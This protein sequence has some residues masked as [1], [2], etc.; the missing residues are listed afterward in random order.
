MSLTT[1]GDMARHYVLQRRNAVLKQDIDDLVK[2]L[3][4]GEIRD[5]ADPVTGEYMIL[6]DI[7]RSL[8][9]LDGYDLASREARIFADTAQAA[10]G[11]VQDSVEALSGDLILAAQSGTATGLSVASDQARQVFLDLVDRL[12]TTVGGRSVFAGIGTSGPALADGAVMLADLRLA[13]SGLS[14]PT[15]IT[16]TVAAWFDDPG[17][18]FETSGYV[19]EEV[20]LA[21]F[22]VSEASE[23]Q[24]T[25]TAY[26]PALRAVLK[27]A[28]LA[29][30]AADDALELCAE[31]QR[32]L[33]QQAGQQIVGDVKG[34]TEL[35][36]GVGAT[37]EAIA[38]GEAENAAA[39]SGFTLLKS[40]MVAA[41]PYETATQLEEPRV[42]LETRYAVTARLAGM[43]LARYLG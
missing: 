6:G 33:L 2:V 42:Q 9:L 21:P 25:I 40:E 34:L 8:R 18:G 35:R 13:V 38:A 1:I 7:E 37:Q 39:R 12:N 27:Q 10:L 22:Q 19:G 29:A 16:A 5:K 36:A 4:S 20:P 28:A 26:D 23:V 3:A 14:N 24:M 11:T 43:T 32:L 41:A 15:D 17:G 31:F 30:L